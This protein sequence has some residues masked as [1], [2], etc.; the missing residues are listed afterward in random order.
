MPYSEAG[1]VSLQLIGALEAWAE[2]PEL[3]WGRGQTI[4]CLD[5][6]CDLSAEEWSGGGGGLSAAGEPVAKIA[7]T[8]NSIDGD[9]DCSPVP[10]G[11]HGTSVGFPSSLNSGGRK[12][13][14]FNDR[15]AQAS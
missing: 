13:L 12:G 11:Y 3:G 7:A 1:A 4:A 15:V 9:E 8:Y 5:D 14:A 2:Y 10:P 6:G